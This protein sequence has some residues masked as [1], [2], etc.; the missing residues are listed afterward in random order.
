M[1]VI[2]PV[3]YNQDFDNG[4]ARSQPYSAVFESVLSQ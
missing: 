1:S 3:A 4:G 2:Y